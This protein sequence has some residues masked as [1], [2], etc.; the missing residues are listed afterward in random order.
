MNRILALAAFAACGG[1]SGL[2]QVSL[3]TSPGSTLLDSVQT[4]TLEVTNPRQVMTAE[5]SGD[6]FEIAIEFPATG[7]SAALIV[8]GF[9]ADGALVATGATPRFALG[10]I[11]GRVVVYMA[12]PYTVGV[13]PAALAVAR[14]EPGSATLPYGAIF[15]G[16][17]VAGGAVND[18]VEIYNAFDHSLVSGLPLPAA[19]AAASVTAGSTGVYVFGGI[20]SAGV[21]AATLWRFDTTVMPTGAYFEIGDKSGF[22]RAGETFIPLGNEQFLLTGTPPAQFLPLAGSLTAR[23]ELDSLPA[24]AAT[25][26]ASDGVATTIFA[27]ATSIVRYRNNQ[28]DVLPLGGRTGAAAV[29]LAGGR[30][31]VVCGTTEAQRIDATTGTGELVPGVPTVAK[32]GCAAAATGRHVVIAGGTTAA[33]VDAAVEVFDAATLALVATT[34][35]TI[36][37]TGAIALTLPNDQILIAGG[38]DATGAPTAVLELFTPPAPE[39]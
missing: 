32:T 28:F 3:T 26:A 7:S 27:G 23:S 10:G 35:L 22:A 9:D 8:E 6:G 4:L 13:A 19:R 1:E 17:R 31:A 16:G 20:D 38:V 11:D 12:T 21:A 29:P 39:R 2:V 25:T 37:R 36:P 24:A 5:R 18:A 15:I 30:V 33:G 34:A 14:S